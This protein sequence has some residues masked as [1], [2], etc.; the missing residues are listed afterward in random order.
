[1]GVPVSPVLA[2]S[3]LTGL[4]VLAFAILG[5]ALVAGVAVVVLALINA[6]LPSHDA[7]APPEGGGEEPSEPDLR[8]DPPVG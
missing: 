3:P 1:M 5:F 8:S 6:V 4:L 7:P 2:S